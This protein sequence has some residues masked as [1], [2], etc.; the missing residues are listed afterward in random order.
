MNASHDVMSSVDA[1]HAAITVTDTTDAPGARGSV[2]AYHAAVEEEA[3][4][5]GE[6]EPPP[7][8]ARLSEPETFWR[9]QRALGM[10]DSAARQMEKVDPETDATGTL[11]L[12][13]EN[14]AMFSKFCA[15]ITS[16]LFCTRKCE[17]QNHGFH[18]ILVQETFARV[19]PITAHPSCKVLT[20]LRLRTCSR[21]MLHDALYL[22]RNL[23][24]RDGINMCF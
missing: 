4:E 14:C 6:E 5:K 16:Q 8:A 1:H 7:K 9:V 17:I 21:S 24:F 11:P 22:L 23:R 20:F 13:I 10:A 15:D 18:V 12:T 2:D 3:E 19:C